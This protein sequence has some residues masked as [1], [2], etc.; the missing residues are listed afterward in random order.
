[1]A[2]QDTVKQAIQ[3]V[4]SLDDSCAYQHGY[5]C[6]NI[7][8]NTF[9]NNKGLSQMLPASYLEAWPIALSDFKK[10]DDLSNEQKKLKHYRIGFTEDK[11]HYIIYFSAFLLPQLDENKQVVGIMRVS[12]GR[13]C[14]YWIDKKTLGIQKRLFF[15]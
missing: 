3:Y 2:E 12:L 11:E 9:S 13:S 8:E 6:E 14:K 7:E 1:M 10:I 5:R 15:K 4:T